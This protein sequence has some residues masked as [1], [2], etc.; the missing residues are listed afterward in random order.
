LHHAL[1]Q[2]DRVAQDPKYR[3]LAKRREFQTTHS[4]LRE[5]TRQVSDAANRQIDLPPPPKR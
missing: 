3:P 2:Y 4:L 1:R 5:Y